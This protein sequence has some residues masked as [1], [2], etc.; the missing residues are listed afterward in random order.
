MSIIEEAAKRL[1]ELRKAGIGKE[2]SS[3]GEQK[4]GEPARPGLFGALAQLSG[5]IASEFIKSEPA[6]GLDVGSAKLANVPSAVIEES[7]DTAPK[8]LSSK[9]SIDLMQLATK[10]IVTPDAPRSQI[11]DEFRVIKRP[12]ISN[13][14][15]K[16]AA[17]IKNGNLI[18]V[19]SALP[20]EGKSFT[21]VNLAMS[22]AM[23][24]DNTVLLIDA[25]VSRPSI[26]NILGLPPANG[27]MD[28][29]LDKSTDL[30]DV[31]IK[32]DIEKLTIV[33]AGTAH[34]RATELLASDSMVNLLTEM[35][36]RYSDRIIIFDSP[37]LLVTTE[38]RVLASHMGQVIV[39]VESQRTSHAAVKQALVTIETC[40]LVLML[41]NKSSGLPGGAYYGQQ[42]SYGSYG[43]GG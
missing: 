9:M 5:G 21:A 30:G 10:G 33:P 37:P 29:L 25:D 26:L 31:M 16:G 39:V 4:D 8:K 15:G 36:T 14:L 23:E 20:G 11:A 7:V 27:L 35:A 24:M 12:L 42:Y 6:P 2:R 28:V 34:Q 40:P 38:A 1:A 41:L 19:T 32:T 18:M 22:I 43:Y 17:P 3:A 13:A